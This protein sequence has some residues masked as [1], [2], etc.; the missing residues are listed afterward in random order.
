MTLLLSAG[1][2]VDK[3]SKYRDTPLIAA[4]NN[5]HV[6]VAA[7]LRFFSK[8]SARGYACAFDRLY[9][10]VR[11]VFAFRKNSPFSELPADVLPL[12]VDS[13]DFESM[14]NWVVSS[15]VAKEVPQAVA[16]EVPQAVAKEVPQ[17]G[18]KPVVGAPT[19]SVSPSHGEVR[20]GVR[21]NFNISAFSA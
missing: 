10:G 8:I 4:S 18:A 6:A 5:G 21:S 12:V 1:A 17:V 11:G 3:E 13:L 19:I 9:L 20:E 16:K 2:D 15:A 14:A 7:I